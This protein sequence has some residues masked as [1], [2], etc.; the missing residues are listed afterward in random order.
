MRKFCSSQQLLQSDI[1]GD[2]EEIGNLL[3]P[4]TVSK[5]SLRHDKIPELPFLEQLSGTNVEEYCRRY[6]L[7]PCIRESYLSADEHADIEA[8]LKTY[9]D[10]NDVRTLLLYQY[11]FA[12]QFIGE[13]YGSIDSVHSS[14]SLILANQKDS[15]TSEAIAGFVKKYVAVN[16]L[17]RINAEQKQIKVFLAS[18]FLLSQ[19]PYK[20]LKFGVHFLLPLAHQVL[21]R[22]PILNV[23]VHMLLT[24]YFL[25]KS[26]NHCCTIK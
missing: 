18:I 7:L 6:Q 9:F 1:S 20:Q 4:F 22:C 10:Q 19:H 17:L 3:S 11:S 14:S 26:W 2:T 25:T 15:T 23:G 16:V 5:G 13:L 24:N 21:F 12:A 8:T